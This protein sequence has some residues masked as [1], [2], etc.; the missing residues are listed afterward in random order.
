MSS[1]AVPTFD[2]PPAAEGLSVALIFTAEQ[3][4]YLLDWQA[5]AAP[6]E[7]LPSLL[8]RT[9]VKAAID[10]RFHALRSSHEQA[11]DAARIED[12]SALVTDHTAKT[13]A[14]VPAPRP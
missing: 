1:V 3:H 9:L 13:T 14:L 2:I 10:N 12:V 4:A 5:R 7:S 6:G 11:L 8:L